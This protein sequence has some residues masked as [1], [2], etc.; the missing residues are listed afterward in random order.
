MYN[1]SNCRDPEYL[2]ALWDGERFLMKTD[3]IYTLNLGVFSLLHEIVVPTCSYRMG[4]DNMGYGA[5]LI[6]G[7]FV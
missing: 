6:G 1:C 4:V 2:D 7:C 3:V 5:A